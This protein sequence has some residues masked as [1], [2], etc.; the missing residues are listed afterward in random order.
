[1][2]LTISGLIVLVVSMLAQQ[3]GFDVQLDEGSVDT[4]LATLAQVFGIL[5]AWVGRFRQGDVRWFGARK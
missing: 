4:T 2:S 3:A 5:M 1:M